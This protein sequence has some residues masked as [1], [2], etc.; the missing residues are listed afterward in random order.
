[1][2]D[3]VSVVSANAP[4]ALE[5]AES[6]LRAGGVIVLPTDTV[7]GVGA[8]PSSAAG[9]DRIYELKGLPAS[10]PIAVL[11]SDR[12]QVDT[13]TGPVAPAVDRLMAAFWPGPLTVVLARRDGDGTVGVRCPDHDFVRALAARVGP[14]AVTSANRHGESTPAE[15]RDAAGSLDGDVDLVI[16]GGPCP[17][18]ASTVVDVMDPSL[19]VLREGQIRREQI[20]AAALR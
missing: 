8:L 13:L 1:V 14:L 20:V 11:V 9:I 5:T 6:A 12:R 10:M 18:T 2:A 16:D 19:P 4:E 17:G 7:Y 3:R 15:A